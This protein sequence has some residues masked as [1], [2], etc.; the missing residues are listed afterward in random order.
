MTITTEF[1]K[2]VDYYLNYK[3]PE[4]RENSEWLRNIQITKSIMQS[5]KIALIVCADENTDGEFSV[6]LK[7]S[8][9]SKEWLKIT[10]AF[11]SKS[12]IEETASRFK[13]TLTPTKTTSMFVLEN[14]DDVQD[15]VDFI[16]EKINVAKCEH[17]NK[18]KFYTEE[19][20]KYI[21][22]MKK[23][24]PREM[25]DEQYKILS[26][27]HKHP[28]WKDMWGKNYDTFLMYFLIYI[29][30]SHIKESIEKSVKHT[31]EEYKVEIFTNRF[32]LAINYKSI[33]EILYEGE[34]EILYKVFLPDMEME[35]EDEDSDA[36]Y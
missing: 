12:V 34:K 20:E 6:D 9:I 31:F 8:E 25:T 36:E 35:L 14:E 15:I 22:E 7:G 24:V 11:D 17:L 29:I 19:A 28:V 18:I 33:N 3:Y 5:G 30:R 32:N 21:E 1:P 2:T 16:K 27:L 4:M 13:G 23:Y 10:G 26:S